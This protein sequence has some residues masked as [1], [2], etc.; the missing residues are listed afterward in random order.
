MPL[1]G[2]DVTRISRSLS[3]IADR[4]D[5][6]VD[7]YFERLEEVELPPAD[8]TL[9]LRLRREEGFA[10]RLVRR[11]RTWLAARDG[12]GSEA[13]SQALRQV[14]RAMPSAAYP[15][16]VLEPIPLWAGVDASEVLAFP[17]RVSEEIRRQHAAF[18]YRL[19]LRRHQ[20]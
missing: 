9:G 12:L 13:F 2:L 3:Q 17:S 14:A 7:A 19:T 5:D 15:E 20:R 4:S 10:V 16:P 6:L 8:Q 18:P 11:G 1:S